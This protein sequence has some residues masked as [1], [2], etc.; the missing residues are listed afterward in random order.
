MMMENLEF[1]NFREK[2]VCLNN[3]MCF[4]IR[5]RFIYDDNISNIL[6]LLS[7]RFQFRRQIIAGKMEMSSMLLKH[8]ER[9]NAKKM[10]TFNWKVDKG[11]HNFN[12]YTLT[13]IEEMFLSGTVRMDKE[14]NVRVLCLGL[15]GGYVNSYLHHHFPEMDITV[16]E[17]YPKM[18]EIAKKWF[19]LSLDRR[20]HLVMGDAWQF[21]D[22]SVEK[23]EMYDIVLLDVCSL[24]DICPAGKAIKKETAKKFSL[25]LNGKGWKGKYGATLLK[26]WLRV[27]FFVH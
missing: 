24:E 20:H 15:G 10:D 4:D 2:S 18:V 1:T 6:L 8:P 25:L 26:I 21:I 23:G 27:R 7:T 3:E 22:T 12:R 13:M 14:A 17:L 5:D 19:D 16:V 11:A 9:L